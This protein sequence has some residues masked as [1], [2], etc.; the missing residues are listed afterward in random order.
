MK[1]LT[2]LI[3]ILSVSASLTF[4]SDEDFRKKYTETY[5]QMQQFHQG[6]YIKEA[7][8]REGKLGLGISADFIFDIEWNTIRQSEFRQGFVSL[9][10]DYWLHPVFNIFAEG[11]LNRSA[12]REV[13]TV[14]IMAQMIGPSQGPIEK[15]PNGTGIE[16]GFKSYLSS[17]PGETVTAFKLGICGYQFITKNLTMNYGIDWITPGF[18]ANNFELRTGVKYFFF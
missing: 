4:A 1:K 12:E 7:M 3:L 11:G 5:Q 8:E 10:A 9:S 14:S 16:I 2:Y 13:W 18:L 17:V 15:V 6:L